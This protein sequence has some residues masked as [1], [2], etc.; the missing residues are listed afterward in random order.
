MRGKYIKFWHDYGFLQSNTRQKMLSKDD[1]YL[2]SV[3][4][5]KNSNRFSS[6]AH[7]TEVINTWIICFPGHHRVIIIPCS[8]GVVW[9]LPAWCEG[10]ACQLP[11]SLPHDHQVRHDPQTAAGGGTPDPPQHR[12]PWWGNMWHTSEI[13]SVA[14]RYQVW[15]V[16]EFLLKSSRLQSSRSFT[17]RR[18]NTSRRM[19]TWRKRRRR[20]GRRRKRTRRWRRG[21]RRRAVG[22]PVESQG[23]RWGG[24]SGSHTGGRDREVRVMWQK[25]Y[26]TFLQVC[27]TYNV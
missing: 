26:R 22:E 21:Q 20:R 24:S 1:I 2:I 16:C 25:H 11:S 10:S 9:R 4:K 6:K 18:V 14:E 3:K 27:T 7:G 12:H 8:V 23:W 19:S 5:S 13:I 15:N 17:L